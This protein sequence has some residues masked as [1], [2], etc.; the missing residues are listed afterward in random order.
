[1]ERRALDEL[2]VRKRRQL[3]ELTEVS[4]LTH[5]LTEAL[6]RKDQVSV[7]MLLN[8][9]E[10]PIRSMAEIDRGIRDYLLTLPEEEAIRYTAL[11]EGE[12]PET[13]EES[14]FCEAVDRFLD[15]LE[16]VIE[17]D[18]RISLRMGGNRSFYKT[19]RE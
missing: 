4:E 1:M 3:T 14:A 2:C 10:A 17:E 7:Q 16:R 19:F 6:D 13:K 12:E 11:L 9:R 15:L 8:M 5:Q 18:R